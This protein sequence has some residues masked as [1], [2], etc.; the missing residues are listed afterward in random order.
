MFAVI[1]TG[2]RQYRVVPDDVLEIGKI[3]GEVGTIVQLGEV[4]VVGGDTPV[5]GTPTV[6]GASVAA[7]V[8]DH[9]R[10]PKVIAFKKR[11]RKNSRRKRGYRDEITVLRVTEILTDNNKP[12]IGP[13]PKREKVV[14][15]A[16][17]GD[18]APT[19]AKKAP[20]KKAAAKK[21]PAKK[22]AAAKGKSDKK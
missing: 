9:K 22:A 18:E 4:L 3:A 2:G 12:S 6:A 20:A 1:K 11:R 14:A 16:A 7:E 10:G 8:L 13:R 19:A 17:E 21:A 5:L 15:P